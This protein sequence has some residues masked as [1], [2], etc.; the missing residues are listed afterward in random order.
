M[1]NEVISPS[2][3]MLGIVIMLGVVGIVIYIVNKA[4]NRKDPTGGGRTGDGR[5]G[6][7][8]NLRR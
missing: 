7:D 3:I 5:T 4:K 2:N 8:R 6:N 1:E